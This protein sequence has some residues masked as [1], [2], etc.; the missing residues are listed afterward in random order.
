MTFPITDTAV[1]AAESSGTPILVTIIF[2]VAVF[3]AATAVSAVITYR[4]RKKKLRKNKED[5]PDDQQ[6]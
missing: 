4:I 6:R 2:C 1:F 3:L 5:H